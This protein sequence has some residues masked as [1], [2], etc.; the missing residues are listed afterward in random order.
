MGGRFEPRLPGPADWFDLWHTH[1][2]WR[3]EGNSKPDV[4]RECLRVLFD[5]WPQVE[6][7][8]AQRTGPWQS[9]VVIN[10][11]DSGQDAVYLHTP[12]PQR[13]NF[14]YQ[15]KDVTWCVDPPPWL[16]EFLP[17]EIEVGRSEFEGATLY[18][19]RR[20]NGAAGTGLG[21]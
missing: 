18:W 10:V 6:V 16:A 1:V 9:W 5:V 13:D 8:A 12:N 19:V 14:P 2:D 4:R 11:A 21:T 15:F 20:P 17:D 7:L 3:G